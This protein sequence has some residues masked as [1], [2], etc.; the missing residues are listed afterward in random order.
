M[1]QLW[2]VRDPLKCTGCRLCEIAC[3]YYH[4]GRIWPEASRI[5]IFTLGPGIEIPHL[6]SQCSDY[7]C[8]QKCPVGA[9]SVNKRT[10]AVIVDYEKCTGC[11]ICIDACPGKVPFLH[12]ASK[13]AVICDLCNGDPQCVKTCSEAGWSALRLVKEEKV[14]GVL[15]PLLSYKLYSRKPEEVAK[16][17]IQILGMEV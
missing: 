3:S 6:C 16:E 15:G 9:L 4:E 8:V 7:P 17:I 5:R 2:I 12:P 11:G 14:P 1:L 10:G 13:K